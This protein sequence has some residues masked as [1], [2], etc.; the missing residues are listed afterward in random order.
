M[1]KLSFFLSRRWFQKISKFCQNLS[2]FFSGIEIV[3]C[4]FIKAWLFWHA[5]KLNSRL[6]LVQS[7][8]KKINWK[9]GPNFQI[10][11]G[12]PKKKKKKKNFGAKFLWSSKKKIFWW[13]QIFGPNFMGVPKKK[14]NLVG[15]N[16]Y[17]V[18]KEKFLVGQIVWEFERKKK[19]FGGPCFFFFFNTKISL[20]CVEIE[21]FQLTTFLLHLHNAH[22]THK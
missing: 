20:L 11:W 10:F 12:V 6:F 8:F 17:W 15:P 5:L 13:G 4:R 19:K 18:S 1:L 21:L 2:Y 3:V 9:L 7:I 14:K 16:F 22:K